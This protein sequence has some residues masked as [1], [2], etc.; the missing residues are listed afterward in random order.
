MIARIWQGRTANNKADAHLKVIGET[1]RPALGSTQGNLGIHILRRRQG[2]TAEF[3]VLSLWDSFDSI[4]RF[5]GPDPEKA[6]YYP[7]DDEYLID[8]SQH[9]QHYETFDEAAT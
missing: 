5:A 3:I 8:R 9:V 6:V 1:G 2:D 7:D 4:R